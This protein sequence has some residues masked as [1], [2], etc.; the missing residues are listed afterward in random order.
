MNPKYEFIVENVCNF[1][2]CEECKYNEKGCVVDAI[3]LET[4]GSAPN[5]TMTKEDLINKVYNELNDR[6]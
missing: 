1:T 3:I 6:Q 5:K 2:T 4:V